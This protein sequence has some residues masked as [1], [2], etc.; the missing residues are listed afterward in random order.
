[1]VGWKQLLKFASAALFGLSMTGTAL[2]EDTVTIGYDTT[3]R[4]KSL[5]LPA[6]ITQTYA[7]NGA[8]VLTSLTYARGT[9]KWNGS[10]TSRRPTRSSSPSSFGTRST[11]DR[12]AG[13]SVTP[14]ARCTAI[15][16]PIGAGPR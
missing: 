11:T 1:M 4:R 10:A 14:S 9:T 2:A 3:G 13:S 5:L 12:R 15:R 6:G 16:T 7:Y 8:D